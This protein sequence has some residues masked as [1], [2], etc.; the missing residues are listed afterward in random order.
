MLLLQEDL[1]GLRVGR[2]ME[3]PRFLFPKSS[4]IMKRIQDQG[5][6]LVLQNDKEAF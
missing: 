3:F 2:G 1:Q 6:N 5:L 4:S